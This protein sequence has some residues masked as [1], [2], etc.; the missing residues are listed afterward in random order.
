MAH[1]KPYISEPMSALMVVIDSKKCL[2]ERIHAVVGL[3]DYAYVEF[4]P[5]DHPEMNAVPSELASLSI[6]ELLQKLADLVPA[7]SEGM[8]AIDWA[9]LWE[10]AKPI[11]WLVIQRI[12]S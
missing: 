11:I 4:A 5:D 8:Q 2:K 1:V 9:S 10:K 3:A 12:I 6:K 7:Q